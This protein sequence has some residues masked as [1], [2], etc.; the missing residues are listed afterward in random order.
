[1]KKNEMGL[2]NVQMELSD[3]SKKWA[4]GK[5]GKISVLTRDTAKVFYGFEGT[6]GY[7]YV[8]QGRHTSSLVFGDL[9][10]LH[11]LNA[12]RITAIQ[13]VHILPIKNKL[14]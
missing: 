2:Y 1:M 10:Y 5:K 13:K 9:M 11:H 3:G 6:H 7:G 14:I 8:S 4:T 12:D